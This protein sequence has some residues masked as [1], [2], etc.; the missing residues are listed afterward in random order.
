MRAERQRNARAGGQ[1]ECAQSRPPATPN[2]P[3]DQ[4]GRGG[5]QHQLDQHAAAGGGRGRK[6][7]AHRARAEPATGGR[8]GGQL[9]GQPDGADRDG[10]HRQGPV[11]GLVRPDGLRPAP[12]HEGGGGDPDEQQHS[13]GLQPAAGDLPWVG[14]LGRGG[15]GDRARAGTDGKREGA[16]L[17]VAVVGR[18]DPPAGQVRAVAEGRKGGGQHLGPPVGMADRTQTHLA[19][20]ALQGQPRPERPDRLGEG[21]AQLGGHAGDP[22]A[23][24]GVA[25]DHQGVRGRRGGGQ[26]PDAHKQRHRDQDDAASTSHRHAPRLHCPHHSTILLQNVGE[27]LPVP[28]GTGRRWRAGDP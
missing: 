16:G 15:A 9:P 4:R 24:R 28:G 26:Q 25:A 14:E 18:D 5:Q 2:A 27:R 21:H 22:G 11:A 3:P 17:Q 12:D 13:G 6:E 23:G 19:S 8:A 20:R 7:R 1:G 10:R